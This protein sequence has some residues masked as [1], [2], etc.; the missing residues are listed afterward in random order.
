MCLNPCR[1]RH[2]VYVP[3]APGHTAGA[4]RCKKTIVLR[5]RMLVKQEHDDDFAT[6]A[7]VRAQ[8]PEHSKRHAQAHFRS[9]QSAMLLLSA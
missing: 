3:Q 7:K 1:A 5:V 2:I 9:S 4:G 6:R 8:L